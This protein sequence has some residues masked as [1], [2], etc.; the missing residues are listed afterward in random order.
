MTNAEIL[1][2]LLYFVDEVDVVE[3]ARIYPYFDSGSMYSLMLD[4][5]D[6]FVYKHNTITLTEYYQE[7]KHILKQR[8]FDKLSGSDQ[9]DIYILVNL[10]YWHSAWNNLLIADWLKRVITLIRSR[11]WIRRR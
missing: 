4:Y 8:F 9:H 11:L 1:G 2:S 3:L 6:V 7:N 10:L 5:D